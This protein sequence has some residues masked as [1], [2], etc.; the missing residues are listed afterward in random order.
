MSMTHPPRSKQFWASMSKQERASHSWNRLHVCNGSLRVF[1]SLA[2]A[3]YSHACNRHSFCR[4][5]HQLHN[6]PRLYCSH[7]RLCRVWQQLHYLPRLYCS[8]HRFFR[9]G[10]QLHSFPR[11]Y[12]AAAAGFPAYDSSCIIRRTCIATI[13]CQRHRFFRAW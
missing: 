2:S 5:W 10:Q 1:P 12:I 3:A 11:L 4:A 6:F 13:T 8:R 7:H 9:A